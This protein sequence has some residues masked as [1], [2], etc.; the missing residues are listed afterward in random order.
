MRQSV[1]MS[2]PRVAVLLV[3]LLLAAL[4]AGA[5]ERVALVLGNGDYRHVGRLANPVNDANL[6]GETLRRLG[7]QVTVRTDLD[8]AAMKEAI[9]AF[10]DAVAAGGDG[11]LALFYYAGH[12]VQV[13]GANYLI[14]VDAD[15]RTDRDVLLKAVAAND[16][17]R[18]LE[19]AAASTNVIILDACR[20]NPF[21]TSS[22]S[23]GRGLARVE[24]PTGS[25]IAY[26]TAPG[27]TA[28]DGAAA[29]SPYSAALAKALTV[30]GLTLEQVF[31]A[32]RVDVLAETA[33]RQTPWEESS[34]TRDVRLIEEAAPSAPAVREQAAPQPAPQVEPQPGID[35]AA[36]A[37][38]TL[39]GSNS[40]AMLETF[41]EM[42]PTSPYAA[43][44]RARVE[45]LKRQQAAAPPPTP[46]PAPAP[47]PQAQA[48]RQV[49]A[50][51]SCDRLWYERNAIF[52]AKGHCFQS[53]R[54]IA[55][56]GPG[57][58]P[59]YGQLSAA[60]Q[61]RVNELQRIERQLGCR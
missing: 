35:P 10:A 43:F 57:C 22:R 48:Q 15:I 23:M 27:Q 52:A 4:P 28:A 7:F 30:P 3:S 17:L 6:L 21:A 41:A 61:R 60:E 26:A 44:A 42:F 54:A 45:E 19:L 46:Q 50:G 33:G 11:T 14:P 1:L 12:G 18:T 39:S 20:D 16:L 32:V 40:V 31:K 58:F 47:A 55:A 53:Q 59:P 8:Q 13:A 34:L 51:W 56:F 37:W 9:S 38:A 5:A 2:M 29:N 49:E 36:Q 24:A 25:L